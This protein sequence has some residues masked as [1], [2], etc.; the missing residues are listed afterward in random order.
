MSRAGVRWWIAA[1]LAVHLVAGGVATGQVH[2]LRFLTNECGF[3]GCRLA[4]GRGSAVA[5][6]RHNAGKELFLTAGHCVRGQIARVEV[7]IGGTWRPAV[8]LGTACD[9]GQDLAV[10]GV[11]SRG[12]PVRCAAVA[13][14]DAL[15]GARVTLAGFPGGLGFR[16]REAVVVEHGYQSVDLVVNVPTV[17][18]ES[19]GGVFNERGELAGIISATGPLPR[20]EQTLATGARR[21]RAFLEETLAK[22]PDCGGRRAGSEQPR[23][24]GEVARLL[25]EI[26]GLRARV[27]ELE[28]RRPVPGPAG[29]PGPAGERGPPGP[30]GGSDEELRRRVEALEQARIPVQILAADGS[31][32]DEASYRVGEVIRLKLAPKGDR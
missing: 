21:I 26:E 25:A 3:A 9:Q 4:E 2:P 6:G 28:S 22:M 18:G 27:A 17:P 14:A 24:A 8:V 32:V 7:G 31:V 13:G 16:T 15:V 29:P 1:G 20:P 23:S 19:G 30:A 5:I 10:L 11:N 12:E